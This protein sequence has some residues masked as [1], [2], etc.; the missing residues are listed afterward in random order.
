[1]VGESA[2]CEFADDPRYGE[3]ERLIAAIDAELRLSK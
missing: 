3:I 1:M 2:G